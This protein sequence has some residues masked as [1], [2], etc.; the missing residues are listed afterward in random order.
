VPR[1][2]A[3]E[4]ITQEIATRASAF[5]QQNGAPV[6]SQVEM[7]S[8]PHYTPPDGP[9]V[10]TLLA[11]WQEVT[12]TPGRPI[13]IGGGT[14][15]RLFKGGVD[16]GPASGMDRYRGHGTDEYLTVDELTRI[17]ELTVTA[18]WKLAGEMER[19]Q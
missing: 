4:K 12:G 1:G 5:G 6:V 15:A 14:Q 8:E 11:A 13:A 10:S 18:L 9:L 3:P 16:F 17:G 19:R 7:S 2:I